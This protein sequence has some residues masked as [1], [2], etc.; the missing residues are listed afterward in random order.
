MFNDLLERLF[1]WKNA[2]SSREEVKR[3]L[4]LTIAYDRAGLN[5]QVL[6]RIKQEILEVVSRYVELNSEELEF[7]IENSDR[8]TALIAN[9]P[10]RRV[11]ISELRS[12]G[13]ADTTSPLES[14]SDTQAN[15]DSDSESE[16]DADSNLD[17][18]SDADLDLD[19]D[20]DLESEPELGKL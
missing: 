18:N 12:D 15:L 1:P 2:I 8:V 5:P 13:D 17:S 14:N 20:S 16:S 10:I 6:D 9:L 7:T 19:S 3:R 11:K 4:K